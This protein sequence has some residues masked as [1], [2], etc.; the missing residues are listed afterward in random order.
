ML[1]ILYIHFFLYLF[2]LFYVY[3]AFFLQAAHVY[4]VV[5]LS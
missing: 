5:R 4:V 1:F 2:D 3:W